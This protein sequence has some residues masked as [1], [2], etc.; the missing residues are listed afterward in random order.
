M[1]AEVLLAARIGGGH[2]VARVGGEVEERM[3]EDLAGVVAGGELRHGVMHV[4]VGLVLQLQRHDGQAVEE[5][6]EINLLVRFAKVEM[7][8]EG[9]AVLA[10][11]A[12]GGA[13]GG[14]GLGVVEPELQPAHLAALGGRAS[15]A[16][17]AP[18]PCAGR[19]I[20]RPARPL[21]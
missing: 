2:H 7:R 19:G 9:D 20:P 11:L 3:L 13:L 1:P 10:V 4:L 14:A 12:G 21:P 18:V 15:R 16:A 17:C 5:E 8:A 6:D